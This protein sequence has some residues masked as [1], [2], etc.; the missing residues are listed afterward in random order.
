MR[1]YRQ[2]YLARLVSARSRQDTAF[3]LPSAR[4]S[5]LPPASA[6]PLLDTGIFRLVHREISRG[7]GDGREPNPPIPEGA[8]VA[9]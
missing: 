6:S 7:S 9:E 1:P 3:H 8:E 4:L 2:R 5:P